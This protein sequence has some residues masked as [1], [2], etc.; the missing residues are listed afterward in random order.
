MLCPQGSHIGETSLGVQVRKRVHAVCTV[1]DTVLLE[2]ALL[3]SSPVLH[4]KTGTLTQV[5]Q[6]RDIKAASS[7]Q[8]S[9]SRQET[10]SRTTNTLLR[11]ETEQTASSYAGM[12]DT[13]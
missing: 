4:L 3:Q 9:Q 10:Q 5:P 12:S 2:S 8:E 1:H 6:S 11:V 13:R 7:R